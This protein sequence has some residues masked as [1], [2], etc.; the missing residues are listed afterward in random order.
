[1]LQVAKQNSSSND[2]ADMISHHAALSQ[3]AIRPPS[4]HKD[5]PQNQGLGELHNQEAGAE[6]LPSLEDDSG[7][8]NDDF[9]I[10][11]AQAGSRTKLDQFQFPPN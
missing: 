5:P 9:E 1:M 8:S 6:D 2:E 7:S 10:G 4:R 11:I 3:Y